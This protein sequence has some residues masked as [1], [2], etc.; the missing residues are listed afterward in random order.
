M[1]LRENAVT[2]LAS[3]SINCQTTDKQ[4]IFTVPASKIL[5][6]VAL[7]IRQPSATLAG[8]EDFDLGGDAAAGDWLQN[9]SLDSYTLVTNQGILM[10]PQAAGPP[11]V[12]AKEIIY[13]AGIVWGI[14][15]ISGSTGEATVTMDLFGYLI[16]A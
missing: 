16:D 8:M 15:I 14:K 12:P 10:P 1:D 2:K 13:A 9:I 3:V 11:I 7:G 4:T 6:P 5:L